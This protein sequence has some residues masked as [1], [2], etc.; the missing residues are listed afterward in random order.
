MPAARPRRGHGARVR[1]VARSATRQHYG[2]AAG[3]RQSGC[4]RALCRGS[5]GRQ[6][7]PVLHTVPGRVPC[8]VLHTIP[9]RVVNRAP[10]RLEHLEQR[11]RRR[12][13]RRGSRGARPLG[14][15][16]HCAARSGMRHGS[17]WGCSGC[18][19]DLARLVLGGGVAEEARQR[20]AR[21]PKLLELPDVGAQPERQASHVFWPAETRLAEEHGTVVGHVANHPADGLID[22]AQCLLVVPLLAGEPAGPPSRPGRRYAAVEELALELHLGVICGREGQAGHHDCPACGVGEVDAL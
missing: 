20:H 4:M 19:C 15:V 18:P 16:L 14:T 10:G 8:H 13:S 2:Q 5:C 17:R 1:S 9:G 3:R 22:G 7:G 12:C 21:L 11:G 6:A